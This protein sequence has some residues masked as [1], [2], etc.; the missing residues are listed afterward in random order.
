M[1]PHQIQ[2]LKQKIKEAVEQS[3]SLTVHDHKGATVGY[4]LDAETDMDDVADNV[5]IAVMDYLEE[6]AKIIEADTATELI[7]KLFE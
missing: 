3:T 5:W 6:T 7:D 2:D 1:L 4:T